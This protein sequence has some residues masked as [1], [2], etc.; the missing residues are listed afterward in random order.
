MLKTALKAGLFAFC[1]ALVSPLILLS[2]I[3][4]RAS[5]GEL[6]FGACAQLLALVPSHLG[7]ILRGA[8]YF[9][10]LSGCSWETYIGFG[11]LFTHRGAVLAANVSTGAYCV[12]GHAHIGPK[13]MMGSRVSVPSGKRQHFGKTGEIVAEAHY[14]T[15][16]IGAGTWVGE[17][18]ILLADVGQGCI[19]SAGAVVTKSMP[20]SCIVGGNPAQVLKHLAGTGPARD[21]L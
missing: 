20:D 10:T 14:D 17:G 6:I 8:Y 2:W 12:L 4:S 1:V 3:E 16:R 9:G 15:V 21:E 18:A 13:V 5:R 7:V 11:S 19:V